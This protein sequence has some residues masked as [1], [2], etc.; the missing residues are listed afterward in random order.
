MLPEI[1]G[2]TILDSLADAVVAADQAGRI[3]YVNRSAEALLG[4]PSGT[5]LGQPLTAIQPPRM[6]AAH[7]AGFARYLASR[8][9]RLIGKPVRVPAMR[10]DGSELDIELTIS[11]FTVGEGRPLFVASLRDLRDRVELERQLSIQRYMSAATRAAAKLTARL[12]LDAV[13]QTVVTTAVDDFD[14]ALAR[15]WLYDRDERALVLRASAGL[16]TATATS[17]RAR[18][19]FETYAG[20][21]G[22]VARTR[23]PYVKNGLVGDPQ[24]DQAWVAQERL[25]AVAVVPLAIHD[26]L[27]GV[28]A[29]FFRTP[30]PQEVLALFSTFAAMTAASVHD[31]AL[32]RREQAAHALAESSRRLL[33]A[34]YEVM[35][36]IA[37]SASVVDAAPIVLRA[38]AINLG[39]SFGAFWLVDGE[40]LR[41]IAAYRDS[42]ELAGFVQATRAATFERGVGLPG[43]VWASGEPLWSVDVAGD[44]RFVR[45]SLGPP[46]GLSTALYFPVRAADGVIAVLEFASKSAVPV[47]ETLLRTMSTLGAQIGQL[48]DRLSATALARENQEL[49][50]TTLRSIGDAV[51]A[52]NTRGTITFINPCAERI[53]GHASAAATGRAINEVFRIVDDAS[54]QMVESPVDRVL[55]EGVAVTLQNHTQLIRRDGTRVAIDHSG[56]PIRNAEGELLGV[57]LVFRDVTE[58]KRSRHRRNFIAEATAILASSLD[59]RSTIANAVRLMVPRLADWCTVDVLGDDGTLSHLAVAHADPSKLAWAKELEERYPPNPNA[60]T[61]ATNVVKTGKVEFVPH[62]PEELLTTG[63]RDAEHLR[64]IRELGLKSYMCLPL[65]ARGRILGAITLIAAESGRSYDEADLAMAEDFA[66]RAGVA[67]DNAMLYQEA[68]EA[69]QTRDEFLSIASHELK[70]PLTSL[71]LNL[72][73]TIRTSQRR[74]LRP[75][76]LRAKLEVAERQTAR[77]T[78]LVNQLLDISRITADRLDLE[79]E[80]VD[81]VAVVREVVTRHTD[82]AVRAGC[83]LELASEDRLVGRWDRTRLDQIVTN[84]LTNAIKYGRG[85][86]VSLRVA[87]VSDAA[88]LEVTDHGIGIA[89]EH[90]LRIFERF[91]RATST[92]H[93][94]GFGLGLW[95]V[96]R[97]VDAFGGSIAVHSEAGQGSRFVVTLPIGGPMGANAGKVT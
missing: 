19:D 66:R 30:V 95:I 1:A 38:I 84:L 5:L 15:V 49:L 92:R 65:I 9:P 25:S 36:A 59:Y 68:Q 60:S 91:E 29:V 83:T 31:V 85:M 88:E 96:R 2:R 94:G 32:F 35:S 71:R 90:Q 23:T 86:P 45:G 21:V 27:L 46:K 33:A 82:E 54:G 42:E 11:E 62:I 13:L 37:S 24:F 20:K 18:L 28:L 16:S 78:K 64:I 61:G 6:R 22:E 39:W 17:S 10:R 48:V 87:R 41:V 93:Y 14:G 74:E 52:T 76:E 77:L 58:E 75:D 67:I 26:E 50:A 47:D 8:V 63:A 51:I 12:D 4:W 44:A 40:H 56:A 72:Q 57:V 55:R 97:I 79:I 89:K 43:A 69:I 80:E 7:D 53:T 34:Q 73:T 3:V 70:T 81:L